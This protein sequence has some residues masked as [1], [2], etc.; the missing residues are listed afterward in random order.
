MSQQESTAKSS[1]D[2]DINDQ[3]RFNDLV[4]KAK[5]LAIEGKV[6]DA[7]EMNRTALAI[8]YSEKLHKRIQ[9]MEVLIYSP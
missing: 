8:F 9:K 1:S 4:M 7:V 6:K 2:L 5:Q 3:Q